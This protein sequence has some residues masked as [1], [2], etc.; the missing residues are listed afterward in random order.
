MVGDR[1]GRLLPC[2]CEVIFLSEPVVVDDSDVLELRM[3][4]SV[5][6]RARWRRGPECV[7]RSG[8]K[9]KYATRRV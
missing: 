8:G 1:G 9:R 2:C 7:G 5:C 6:S 3:M 4:T